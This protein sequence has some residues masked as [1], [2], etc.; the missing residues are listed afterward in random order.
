MSPVG[1]MRK[2]RLKDMRAL[3]QPFCSPPFSAFEGSSGDGDVNIYR[4]CVGN[5]PGTPTAYTDYDDG[6]LT[7]D[8]M[9]NP[10]LSPDGTLIA[11]TQANASTGYGEIWVVANTPGS[12]PTQ[13]VAD[14]GRWL[15]YPMWS[16]DS[17][18]IVFSR[19]NAAGNIYGGTIETVPAAGG[20]PTVLHT[21]ATN[22]RAYRPAYSYDGAYIAFMVEHTTGA[23]DGL[24]VMED[25]GSNAAEIIGV[26]QYRLDG[27]QFGWAN[28]SLA[29]AYE[30]GATPAEVYVIDHDGTGQT[31]INTQDTDGA[32]NRVGKFCWP[33]DDSFVA[34]TSNQGF[35][36][37]S[38]YRCETDGS[39]DTSLNGS[40][41]AMN[42]AWFK[43]AHIAN[44]RVWFVETASGS[45]GGRIASV[46]LD[47][48]DYVENLDVNDDTQ[49]DWLFGGNGFEW[50]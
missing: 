15:M 36:Y 10:V 23:D 7:T 12:T 33:A 26:T 4:S 24:W 32:A 1:S 37:W 3:V 30:D 42:Q 50:Q 49:V 47:G 5:P 40:H 43:Q 27:S 13:L 38:L 16:P 34:I 44:S 21:P 20:S 8:G 14:S 41:G 17:S 29:L 18:T 46:A 39:G 6:G 31:K 11:Y 25:D 35:G 2:P 19:G 48:T 22:Y 28:G 45:N 9:H